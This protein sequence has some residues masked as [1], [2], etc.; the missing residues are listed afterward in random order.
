[1]PNADAPER[2][3][4]PSETLFDLTSALER[5][6]AEDVERIIRALAAFYRVDLVEIVEHTE[7]P[8]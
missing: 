4:T 8:R 3:P 1:M 2:P 6:D 7:A 5:H